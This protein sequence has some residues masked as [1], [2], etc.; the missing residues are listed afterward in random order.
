MQ[1]KYV[2]EDELEWEVV[3]ILS[4]RTEQLFK[5]GRPG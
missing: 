4:H 1:T 5:H 2:R 3:C